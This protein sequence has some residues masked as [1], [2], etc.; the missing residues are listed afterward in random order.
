MN[1]KADTKTSPPQPSPAQ[2]RAPEDGMTTDPSLRN[3]TDQE[4]IFK[5][6]EATG[7][8]PGHHCSAKKPICL[9]LS[10]SPQPGRQPML[11]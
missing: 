2:R 9:L 4:E 7:P 6:T 10:P 8:S 11:A 5:H 3:L 1:L